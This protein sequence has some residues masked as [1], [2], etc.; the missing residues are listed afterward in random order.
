MSF[1]ALV[2]SSLLSVPSDTAYFQSAKPVWPA[3]RETERNLCL[4]FRAE[5]TTAPNDRVQIRLTASTLY[6]LFVN[7]AHVG[8]G[9]ARGPHGFYRVDEIDLAHKVTPG[10]NVVAVEVAGYNVN[11]YYLLDQPSF[12]QA[13]ILVNGAVVAS[14][15]GDGAQFTTHVLSERE[16]RVQ[17]Y[18]F[19]R[20]FSEVYRLTPGYD[21]WRAPGSAAPSSAVISAAQPSKALLPRR[22]P[23]P[24]FAVRS[25]VWDV[26]SGNVV[27][28][29]KVEKLHKDRALTRIDDK[30]KGYP[31]SELVSIPS[32][33]LQAV[34]NTSS[35]PV[36]QP[37]DSKRPITLG[38]NAHHILDFGVNYTGF[39]GAR[40]TARKPTRLFITFD[41]IL[42]EGD[43]DAK[44]MGCVNIIALDVTPGAPIDFESYEPYTFRYAKFITLDGDCDLSDIRLRE[45]VNPDVWAA[46]FA[47][48]DPRLNTLFAAGRE[49]Y[50][51]NAVDVFTDCPSRERAGWLCDS[52]SPPASNPIS[53]D[54]PQSNTTSWKTTFSL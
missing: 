50:Q 23:Y 48:S 47:C 46:L 18:S 1:L 4:G 54:Q 13:E 15:G 43:V 17:R 20:P 35:A 11:S 7:G 27:S 21:A 3:G 37:F 19:Q 28:G 22:V 29:V 38:S 14:T 10:P 53:P 24:D 39:V 2:V 16:Q 12:L 36:N 51:Q 6:R 33:E 9:P 30:L 49:T 42:S 8:Y 45:Y 5:F 44:R 32:I 41:E 34:R 52:F 26:A 40:V 31:E 25:P